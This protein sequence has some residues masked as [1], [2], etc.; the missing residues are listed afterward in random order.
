M[1]GCAQIGGTRFDKVEH[2]FEHERVT[3]QPAESRLRQVA[4]LAARVRQ[5]QD[6]GRAQTP[7]AD[8]IGVPAALADLLP[9]GGLRPGAA[10]TVDGST[11]LAVALVA[12]ASA[13][14]S[15]CGAVGM[16]DLGA[17]AAADLGVALDRFVLVP[18][19]GRDW[20]GVLATLV[21]VLTVVLVCPPD[22]VY[23]AE[24][25]RLAARLRQHGAVLISLRPWPR[26]EAQL[27]VCDGSWLGPVDGRGRLT[28][29]Q[30]DVTVTGRGLSRSRRRRLWLPD[31]SG[32][33]RPL[34]A[35][36][37]RIDG[38]P[39]D[40]A[41]SS[42]E[43]LSEPELDLAPDVD[44]AELDR[45]ELDQADEPATVRQEAG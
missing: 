6:R 15:W 36:A 7:A 13:T 26:S 11:A 37:E 38:A 39:R 35:D 1:R 25:S 41:A 18:R 17:E 4:D 8:P 14:G 33:V 32:R 27:T 42:L 40:G 30:A 3:A 21:D 2:T 44:L 19:P 43:P 9:G 28:G 12:E 23:D 20:V 34:S 22:R 29:R 16:P 24:A 31:P 5:V 45:A 10:Y